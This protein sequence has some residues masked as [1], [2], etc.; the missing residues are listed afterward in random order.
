MGTYTG[1][2]RTWV[3]AETVTAALMNS[4]IRDPLTALSAAWTS[5][6]PTLSSFTAGN[7]TAA[8]YYQRFGKTIDFYAAFTFGSTSAAAANYPQL[9]LPATAARP[10]I[11]VHG[12][13]WDAS[14]SAYYLAVAYLSSTTNATLAMPG[15]NGVRTILSTTLPF[16]WTTSDQIIVGGRYEAA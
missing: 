14:A 8:G 10:L 7:G 3:A 15:T 5:Y 2:P 13:F 6:T 1:T 16:T 12:G 4:D 9:T 11:P